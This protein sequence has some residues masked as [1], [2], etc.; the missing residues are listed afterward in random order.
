MNELY[1][2]AVDVYGQRKFY[3]ACEKAEALAWL[4]Y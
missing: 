3:P 2:R 4:G 1:I